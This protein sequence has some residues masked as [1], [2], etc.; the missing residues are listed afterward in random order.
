MKTE[1]ILTAVSGFSGAG[2]GTIMNRLLEKHPG[3]RLSVSA[4][5]RQPREGEIDGVHYFFKTEEEFQQMIDEGAF[6]EYAGYTGHRYGTPKA[7][8]EEMLAQGQDVILEIDVQGALKVKEN[9]PDMLLV[10]VTAPS[11]E[12]IHSRLKGRGS[13]SEEVIQERI[14]QIGREMK[15]IP[16]YDYLIVNEDVDESAETFHKIVEAQKHTVEHNRELIEK[17]AEEVQEGK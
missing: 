13:E 1:G 10:F 11:I 5:T 15:M 3:Y 8:V 4:T 17:L 9:H 16:Y 6:L 12:E 14:A 7:Y 2:K